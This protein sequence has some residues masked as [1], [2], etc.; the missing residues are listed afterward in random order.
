VVEPD[1]VLGV[2]DRLQ[3]TLGRLPADVTVINPRH[4]LVGQT[5]K[6]ERSHCWNGVV[7]LVVVLPDG[8]PGRLPVADTDLLGESPSLSSSIGTVLSVDG[9]RRLRVIAGDDERGR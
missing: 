3:Q 5:L 4:P 7:W 1:A 9:I 2:G 8:F 6:A